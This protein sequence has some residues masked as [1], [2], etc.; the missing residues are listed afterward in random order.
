MSETLL[1]RTE[2]GPHPGTRFTESPPF[3]W[4]LPAT[5]PDAGGRYVKV[6]ESSLPAMGDGVRLL[7][8]AEYEWEPAQ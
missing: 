4:P 1:I 5:L 2:G 3:S 7:R 6:T 8:G